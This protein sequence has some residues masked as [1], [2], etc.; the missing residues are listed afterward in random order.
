MCL[1][2]GASIMVKKW[3][4]RKCE[5]MSK[6]LW[7]TTKRDIFWLFRLFER[8]ALKLFGSKVFFNEHSKNIWIKMAVEKNEWFL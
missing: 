7:L 3:M 4:K 2:R 1:D 6:I 5:I 8:R